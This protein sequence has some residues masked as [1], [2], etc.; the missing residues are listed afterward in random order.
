MKV[1]IK[2]INGYIVDLVT[3]NPSREDYI[4][5]EVESFPSNVCNGCYQ[6]ID[7]GF[8]LDEAKLSDMEYAAL[9]DEEK[10]IRMTINTAN[11]PAEQAL[12]V[13]NLF[14]SWTS[15]IGKP[16][17]LALRVNDE[18]QLYECIQPHTVQAHWKPHLTPAMWKKVSLEEFPEW[19]QPLGAHD[20]YNTGDKV[21]HNDKKWVST[22]NGNVWEP[23]VAG[24]DEIK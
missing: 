18:D 11:L 7:G 21:T 8:V 12:E 14:P 24:W 6:L 10:Y 19:K 23:G 2:Q 13:Q 3:Y 22:S 1:Y 16:T 15:F 9:S 17:A 4:E 20:A 5:H